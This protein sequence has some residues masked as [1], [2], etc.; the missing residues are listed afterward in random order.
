[1]EICLPFIL[2]SLFCAFF[3]NVLTCILLVFIYAVLRANVSSA[4]CT[5]Y[6]SVMHNSYVHMD[7]NDRNKSTIRLK[8][9]HVNM[10]VGRFW[11]NSERSEINIILNKRGCLCR[12]FFRTLSIR[13]LFR[14]V[15]NV[16]MS[17]VCATSFC[18]CGNR[19]FF[20]KQKTPFKRT[21]NVY[22]K[23][24]I[25]GHWARGEE[26]KK[27]RAQTLNEL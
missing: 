10:P 4:L 12:S 21:M 1:M 3:L 24:Y 26:N 18:F 19:L 16:H 9:L 13:M 25:N 6:P 23:Y 7:T 20:N 27:R 11:S 15:S 14:I 8:M 17:S 2:F 5:V 22:S